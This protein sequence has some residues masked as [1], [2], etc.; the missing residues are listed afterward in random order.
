MVGSSEE[1]V[2]PVRIMVLMVLLSNWVLGRCASGG[3]DFCRDKRA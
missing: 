3:V 1:Y 2:A